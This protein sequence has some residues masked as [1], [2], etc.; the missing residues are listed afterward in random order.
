ML[1]FQRNQEKGKENS[2]HVPFLRCSQIT[3]GMWRF[4]VLFITQSEQDQPYKQGRGDTRGHLVWSKEMSKHGA[5]SRLISFISQSLFPFLSSS[6]R[7]PTVFLFSRFLFFPFLG[8]S[9]M[10]YPLGRTS[11]LFFVYLCTIPL[12]PA[13]FFL[14]SLTEM[15]LVSMLTSMRMLLIHRS[16]HVRC[17]FECACHSIRL[18]IQYFAEQL[19]LLFRLLQSE[20][21]PVRMRIDWGPFC[22]GHPIHLSLVPS[23][24]LSTQRNYNTFADILSTPDCPFSYFIHRQGFVL[25][26]R[27]R[28][29]V[30]TRT[31]APC[32]TALMWDPSISKNNQSAY[33]TPTQ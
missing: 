32:D 20:L 16:A 30:S 11:L 19:F 2:L 7:S 24:Q 29:I 14:C 23:L 31:K 28:Y 17:V 13:Q 5:I 18:S 12:V 8:L 1:W 33:Q 22:L 6:R 3:V 25:H 15:D 26:V 27:Y 9:K 4:V 10:V 21:V